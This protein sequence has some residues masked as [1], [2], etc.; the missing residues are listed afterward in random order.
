MKKSQSP[1]PRFSIHPNK[2]G[3]NFLRV[4]TPYFPRDSS[5]ER[6]KLKRAKNKY[7]TL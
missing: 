5:K 1:P 3:E 2:N 6:V 7:S 4:K